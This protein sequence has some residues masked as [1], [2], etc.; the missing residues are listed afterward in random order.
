MPKK[1]LIYI[2]LNSLFLLLSMTLSWFGE[3]YTFFIYL[4][5]FVFLLNQLFNTLNFKAIFFWFI[6]SYIALFYLSPIFEFFYPGE[7]LEGSSNTIHIYHFL[8]ISSIHLFCIFYFLTY[9]ENKNAPSRILIDKNNFYN[10]LYFMGAITLFS[11]AWMLQSGGGIS[12][13]NSSRVDLKYVQGGK[14]LALL[15]T[16]F[17]STFF[18]LL[19]I[20]ISRKKYRFTYLLMVLV[21]FSIL[22]TVYFVSLRNRTM[23]LMHLLAVFMGTLIYKNIIFNDIS[24][25]VQDNFKKVKVLPLII[26][27]SLL[28]VLGI[29]IRFARGVYLEGS[30][31]LD[32]SF[33]DMIITSVKSGDIGYA[34]MV[35]RV[36]DY[37]YYNDLVLNG[38]SYYRLLLALVPSS[39]YNNKTLTTDALIGQKLTGLDVMTIPPGVFGDAYLNFG[40]FSFIVFIFYGLILGIIDS[41]RKLLIS[42]MFFALSFTFIYHFVRG[43]FVNVIISLIFVYAGIYVVNKILKPKYI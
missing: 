39:I 25:V 23:I 40:L 1:H 7:V 31:T 42:H 3:S 35:I 28:A 20:L 32:I 43:S 37:A 13:I 36:I 34:N 38:Q 11:A 8:N 6:V 41:S 19:G 18:I 21:M 4:F 26:S 10:A 24:K 29:F 5:S 2:F 14:G 33:K 9:R 27:L 15:L 17:S 22:E 16:Y 30:G 12:A